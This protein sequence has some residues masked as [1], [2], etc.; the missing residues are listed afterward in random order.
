[1]TILVIGA[2]GRVGRHVVEQLVSR[3]AKV[4]ILT[5]DAS[6]ADVPI[7]VEVVQGEILDLDSLRNAFKG[8][9]LY[10]S[11]SPRDS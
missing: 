7:D 6:K 10:T 3:S 9:L 1:M 4:R 8:C 5:R 11:P 2:T